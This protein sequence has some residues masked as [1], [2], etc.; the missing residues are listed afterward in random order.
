MPPVKRTRGLP[1]VFAGQWVEVGEY[2]SRKSVTLDSSGN[3][4][5]QFDV[6][7]SNQRYVIKYVTVSTNQAQTTAPYPTATV[8]EG[9]Q[10]A[11]LMDGATWT[12]NQDTFTGR[13]VVDAGTDLL[14]AFTGG[15]AGSIA[16]ASIEGS[17]ELVAALVGR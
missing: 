16:T 13:F 17:N 12:G 11:G 15:V 2:R 14:V 7:S 5:V 4:T 9:V 1:E 6:R 3:G 8:Y 10:Q